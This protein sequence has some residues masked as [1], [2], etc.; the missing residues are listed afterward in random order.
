MMIKKYAKQALI[1]RVQQNVCALGVATLMTMGVMMPAHACQIPKSYYKHVSCTA[2]SRYFLAVK[3]SGAPVA[4]LYRNGQKK[5]DLSRYTQGDASKL[6]S[7]LMPVQR[8]GKLGYVNMQGREVVPAVYDILSA[9]AHTKGWARAVSNDRIVVKKNGSFGVINTSN[10]V[11]VPFSSAYQNIS[12]FN[13]GV[14]QVRKNGT[15]SWIDSQGRAASNPNPP[16]AAQPAPPVV[17]NNQTSASTAPPAAATSTS[18]HHTESNVR[19]WQPV[20]RNGKWGFINA[21]GVPMITFSFD[22][23]KPF[24]EGLAG[25]RIDDLWGFVNLAGDLVIPFRFDQQGVVTEGADASYHGQ[26][27]FVFT[28]GK[29]WIGNLQNGDKMCIDK[30]GNNVACD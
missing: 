4:L 23:V 20:K 18:S 9:D 19:V 25:V 16:P 24:S 28:S 2:S 1:N 27:A 29:A 15:I 17:V 8:L 6:R 13:Q 22:E 3:D 26:S 30:E 5:V 7:G 11:I 10:K 12:D 21:Q 14:A